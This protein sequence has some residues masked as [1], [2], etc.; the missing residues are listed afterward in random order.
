MYDIYK[1]QRDWSKKLKNTLLVGGY[2]TFEDTV[3]VIKIL[4]EI[5]EAE[6]ENRMLNV[7]VFTM[8]ECQHVDAA[9]RMR[10]N[11]KDDASDRKHTPTKDMK[12][13]I[14]VYYGMD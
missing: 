13:L 3:E 5:D 1:V 9:E 14:N 12:K 11:I 7:R 6:S 10:N 4:Y 8:K 2:E